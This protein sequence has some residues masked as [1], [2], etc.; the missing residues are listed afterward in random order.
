VT[1]WVENTIVMRGLDPRIYQSL[2]R[3]AFRGMD[4]RVKPGHDDVKCSAAACE[5]TKWT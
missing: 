3:M 5:A 1:L 2:Q 4:S